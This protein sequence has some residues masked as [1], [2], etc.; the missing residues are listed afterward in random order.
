M[1]LRCHVNQRGRYE[2]NWIRHG[3]QVEDEDPNRGN[4]GKNDNNDFED[5]DANRAN[6]RQAGDADVNRASGG[7]AMLP[8]LGIM[9]RFTT[10]AEYSSF[11]AILRMPPHES[12][13]GADIIDSV[14]AGDFR[15]V[16]H[17]SN[18]EHATRMVF[19]YSSEQATIDDFG[20]TENGTY[21]SRPDTFI[22]HTTR[23]Y[24]LHKPLHLTGDYPEFIRVER[25]NDQVVVQT[26][27]SQMGHWTE[28]HSLTVPSNE[29]VVIGVGFVRTFPCAYTSVWRCYRQAD[30]E[31]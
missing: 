21:I 24:K 8:W 19:L 16:V 31:G 26:S 23:P 27:D 12:T 11:D 17:T 29:K 20:Y 7:P 9:K 10:G 13:K 14:F 28:Q 6:I 4:V 22:T 5:D 2:C 15:V 25:V 18:V 30:V 3:G 1:P